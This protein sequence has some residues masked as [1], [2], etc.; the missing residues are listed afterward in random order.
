MAAALTASGKK[1]RRG[2]VCWALE[3][4]VHH[5]AI[6]DLIALR[7]KIRFKMRPDQQEAREIRDQRALR[8][9]WSSARRSRS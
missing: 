2:A 3:T 8:R 6:K 1:S 5:R 9:Q 4:V 7:G